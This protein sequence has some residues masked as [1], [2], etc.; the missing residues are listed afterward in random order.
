[1]RICDLPDVAGHATRAV[2]SG[3]DGYDNIAVVP[4]AD[5]IRD[6]PDEEVLHVMRTKGNTYVRVFLRRETAEQ[7][8]K[9]AEEQIQLPP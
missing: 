7:I 5:L 8:A 3:E 4:L 1:M 6:Y 9:T 2:V